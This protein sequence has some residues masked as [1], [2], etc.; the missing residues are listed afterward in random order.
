MAEEAG[1]SERSHASAPSQD[2]KDGL[3]R[4]TAELIRLI[5]S[6]EARIQT[7]RERLITAAAA[8]AA[9]ATPPPPAAT[10]PSERKVVPH[11]S[12]SSLSLA[13]FLKR[14]VSRTPSSEEISSIEE[15]VTGTMVSRPGRKK[16]QPPLAEF[17]SFL[18][19]TDNTDNDNNNNPNNDENSNTTTSLLI[20]EIRRIAEL[21][22]IGENYVTN[23]QNEQLAYERR[24]KDEWKQARDGIS[25]S[26]RKMSEE[27][28][29][30]PNMEKSQLF[31]IFLERNG[32]A[33]LVEMLNG[34]VFRRA[35]AAPK[36]NNN[37]AAGVVVVVTYLPPISVAIQ[38]LQS[39]CILIQ[40]VSRATSLYALL[41]NNHVNALIRLQLKWYESAEQHRIG[42]KDSTHYGTPAY[43][44]LTTH[45]VTFLKSLAMRMNAETLQF[46]L[47]YPPP[48]SATVE[49]GPSLEFPLYEC[50]LQLCASQNDSF[51]RTTALNICLNTLRLAAVQDID[52][53][54]GGGGA[55]AFAER[56][57]IA[58]YACVPA[59]VEQLI[60]PVFAKLALHWTALD[61]AIRAM[62]ENRHMSHT[63][64]RNERVVLAKEKVRRERL[65]RHFQEAVGHLHDEL[66][67]L[68]DIFKVRVT[69]H[70]VCLLLSFMFYWIAKPHI[71]LV[72]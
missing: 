3:T 61:E 15:M 14:R 53:L 65:I 20:E 8:G 40:N 69:Q 48:P 60:A 59:T 41:S 2:E 72:F 67:L 7:A 43:T 70:V 29:P 56:V 50:S 45:F 18:A 4:P 11:Q 26:L 10:A 5:D 55:I 28:K 24:R 49:A 9:A 36:N 12:S 44:E 32:M 30:Q 54:L 13:R 64:N 51:V 63:T 37:Q 39:I 35:A 38:A 31:D 19:D 21:C 1:Y 16:D 34:S 57:L 22:V 62:D 58:E 6:V 66:Y 47:I 68:D 33:L 46:F 25:T 71:R 27:E 52:P 17:I 42:T 23:L